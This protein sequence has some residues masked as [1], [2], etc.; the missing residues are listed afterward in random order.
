[1]GHTD[2]K[3]AG[4]VGSW[5]DS[6]FNQVGLEDLTQEGYRRIGRI[7]RPIGESVPGGL[8]K[9]AAK[10][11]I[12]NPGTAVGVSIIDAHA[13]GIGVFGALIE[14][15]E[16]T[17]ESLNKRLALIGGTSSCHMVVSKSACFVPG[18]WETIFFSYGT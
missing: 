11:L 17:V 2:S 13:G 15:R 16:F 4:S 7:A 12:I 3:I 10:E 14:G 6:Y 18:V 8:S 1:M 9:K 5:N